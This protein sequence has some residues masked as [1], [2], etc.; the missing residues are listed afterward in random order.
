VFATASYGPEQPPAWLLVGGGIAT[1][2]L[3]VVGELASRTLFF[4]AELGPR[5]PGVPR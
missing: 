3:V 1:L 5:M 4:R 2:L